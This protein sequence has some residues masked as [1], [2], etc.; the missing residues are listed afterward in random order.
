MA[1]DEETYRADDEPKQ[2]RH[3]PAPRIERF[4]GEASCQEKSQKSAEEHGQALA[5]HLPRSVIAAPARRGAF[6]EERGRGCELPTRSKSLK[7]ACQYDDQWRPD[8]DRF[9]R[10]RKSD[11]ANC[12]R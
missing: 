7:Q 12:R 6:D 4:R 8:A 3:S 5:D 1:A 2:E 10:R 9:I 11:H